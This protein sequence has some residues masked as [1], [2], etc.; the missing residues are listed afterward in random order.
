MPPGVSDILLLLSGTVYRTLFAVVLILTV[1]NVI[2]KLTSLIY[3]LAYRPCLRIANSYIWQVRVLY[4]LTYLLTPTL[5]TLLA[6]LMWTLPRSTVFARPSARCRALV[7]MVMAS[8]FSG[9]IARP[10]ISNQCCTARKKSDSVGAHLTTIVKL[11]HRRRTQKWWTTG[12]G[13]GWPIKF[14]GPFPLGA[15]I[16]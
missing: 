11:A 12:T 5:R 7:P 9:F 13:T 8:V 16:T 2:L 6:G 1:L 10:L 3:R 14:P 4:L 15:N